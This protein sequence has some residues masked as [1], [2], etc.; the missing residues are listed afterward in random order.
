MTIIKQGGFN[1]GRQYSRDGQQVYWW[2]DEAGFVTFYDRSRCIIGV[3]QPCPYRITNMAEWIM[4]EYDAGN[5]S[6]ACQP[7]RVPEDFD[8]GPSLRL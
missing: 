3:I 5:Y 8:F 2:Q 6:M 1:T 7:E 4:Q